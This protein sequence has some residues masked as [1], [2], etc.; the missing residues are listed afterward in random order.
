MREDRIKWIETTPAYVLSSTGQPIVAEGFV[1]VI[2]AQSMVKIGMTR[3]S[4]YRRWHSLRTGNPWLEVPI[5]VSPPLMKRVAEMEKA[6]H[7]A[8]AEYRRSG[9]WFECDRGLA[10]ETV[11]RI[12][13]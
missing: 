13:E 12:C 5:Y 1:Y 10:V 11:R 8:L 3:F 2:P 7:A 6:C 9:E 4:M